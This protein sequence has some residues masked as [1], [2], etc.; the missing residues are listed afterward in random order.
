M[1]PE[2]SLKIGI[3]DHQRRLLALGQ[4]IAVLLEEQHRTEQRMHVLIA[5]HIGYQTRA[6][7]LQGEETW[8]E[9]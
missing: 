7:I 1:S 2:Q 4:Q 8:Q 5:A 3:T 9:V 6:Y